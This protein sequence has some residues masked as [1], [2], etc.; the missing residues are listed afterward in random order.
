MG[1]SSNP[2]R[3]FSLIELLIVVTI[4]LIISTIAV[5]SLLRA[6]QATNEAASAANMKSINI[7]QNAY[8]STW[9][10]FATMSQLVDDGLL[11]TRFQ[12]NLSGY[13][14]AISVTNNQ[15]D[16]T[17]TATAVSTTTGRYDY[18]SSVDFVV[19]YTTLA[20]RAPSGQAGLPV[21]GQ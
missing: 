5:P 14:F 3:G 11:D 21:T 13:Q 12:G 9:H 16:F 19:R 1:I 18:Y 7:A 10:V 6:R 15:M 4:I 2:S 17:A 20:S 8:V